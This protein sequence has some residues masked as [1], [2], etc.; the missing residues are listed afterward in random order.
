MQTISRNCV[1]FYFIE[2]DNDRATKLRRTFCIM[3]QRLNE[4]SKLKLLGVGVT[5]TG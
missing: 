2:N 4:Y 5:K 3:G 1:V